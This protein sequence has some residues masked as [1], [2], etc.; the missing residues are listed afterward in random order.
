MIVFAPHNLIK[1]AP[2]TRL[3]LVTC[4]NMLI[5]LQPLAQKKVMS[6]FHFGLTT[7]G[8]LFLGS[9]ETPGELS[10]EFE[11]VNE[12][13]KIY[14]KR[15]DVRLPTE[16]C[17]TMPLLP[18]PRSTFERPTGSATPVTADHDLLATYDELLAEF[19][20]PGVLINEQRN[21]LQMFGGAGKYLRLADGRTDGQLAGPG[22]RRIETGP[23][24]R[25][26]ARRQ[27][28][29]ECHLQPDSNPFTGRRRV[30]RI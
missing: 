7:P 26:A 24:R 1:D 25:P 10:D 6:L 20:P 18:P 23:D 9:S 3:H 22:R 27:G 17:L 2:F 4:R 14:R 21:I 28:R 30:R 19:M 11:T 5:Y 29:P 12:R 8:V 16:T 15:R 13:W